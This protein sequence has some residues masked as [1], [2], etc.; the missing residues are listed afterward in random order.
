MET[1]L[2][3]IGIE[4]VVADLDRAIELFTD[5]LGCD[6]LARGPAALIPGETATID[7]GNIIISL[8]APAASGEGTL[9]ALRRPR[10]S[11]VIFGADPTALDRA[12]LRSAEHGLPVVSAAGRFHIPPE[13]IQGALG[14]R[15]AIV[16]TGL[17]A[18]PPATGSGL[19]EG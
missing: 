5:V 8:L 6:L 3:A 18:E 14:E 2:V 17:G 10:L 4:L 16:V 15:I 12:M 13:A 11:Q 7:A 1:P 19:D 9:L